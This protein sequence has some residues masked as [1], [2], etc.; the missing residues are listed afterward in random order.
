MV[1]KSLK[2]IG[3]IVL[4][5]LLTALTQV[6]GVI[7][8]IYLILWRLA[9]RK[10][11]RI[12]NLKKGV[13]LSIKTGGF[14]VTY[15]LISTL[16]IPVIAKQLGR[17]PLPVFSNSKVQPLNIFTCLLNRHYVKAEMLTAVTD[18][19]ESIH[20][21]HPGT[22]LA[23]LDAN[24]PFFDGFPL[25]PHKSHDDGEKLDLAFF[26]KDADTKAPL[27][28]AAPS[29]IGYG[30]FEKPTKHEQNQPEFCRQK[31]YWQYSI[32]S[33]IVPQWNSKYYDFDLNRTKKLVE[34]FASHPSI[35]KIFIEPH[36]KTRMNLHSPK[37]RYHG[38]GAVRH[39]DHIHIQL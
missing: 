28:D 9:N 14:I 20:S 23:Y 6:G 5:L 35:G 3:I 13:R 30:V 15:V 18:V 36:L 16:I 38:C 17:V 37:I 21:T 29:F 27:N 8:I 10:T 4:I 33:S 19:S 22:T 34:L 11:N 7:L 32:L 25:L 12:Q 39:D 26:Y 1:K 2:W 24:F 31:G